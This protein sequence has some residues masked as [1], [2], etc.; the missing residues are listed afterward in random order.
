MSVLFY[1][2]PFS[3]YNVVENEKNP[4]K[5]KKILNAKKSKVPHTGL[6][7][8]VSENA[9]LFRV[10]GHF[11]SKCTE[12]SPT[13]KVNRCPLYRSHKVTCQAKRKN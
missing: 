4:Q 9:S 3:R 10:N 6:S 8:V 5:R 7:H 2:Q 13:R 11:E 12:S 1:D